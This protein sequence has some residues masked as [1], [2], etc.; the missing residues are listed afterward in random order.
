MKKRYASYVF[1]RTVIDGQKV[2]VQVCEAESGTEANKKTK[3]L[4]E[5]NPGVA[6]CAGNMWPFVMT[7]EVKSVVYVDPEDPTKTLK[8]VEVDLDVESDEEDLSADAG[9]AGAA[10]APEAPKTVVEA[11]KAIETPKPVVEA[12]KAVVEPP[13]AEP[14]PEAKP[15]PKVETPKV[16]TPKVETPKVTP[17][18]ATPKPEAQ[19]PAE[20]KPADAKA[21]D[22]F[23]Q[24]FDG[25]SAATEP[26]A[27]PAGFVS[28][29]E[30][31]ADDKDETVPELF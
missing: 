4:A 27:A 19:K 10:V 29:N 28:S 9:V 5:A 31:T 15:T 24:L 12:P 17:K 8:D 18:P 30:E 20:D 21:G 13:K 22:G 26:E 6:Y 11:P 7:K 1:K 2:L 16:E 14:V 23:S 3:E 25:A